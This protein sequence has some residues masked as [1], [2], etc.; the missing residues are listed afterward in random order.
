MLLPGHQAAKVRR[1]AAEL[2]VR[3]LGGD[4]SLVE[5]VCRIR[6]FQEE[7][8][9]R[10]PEDPRRAFGEAI[11]AAS[12][13]GGVAGEQLARMCTEIVTRA[14]P[15]VLEKLTAHIDERL[16]HLD[17][18]QRVKLNVRTP[19]RAS[20]YP[21]ATSIAGAGRPYPLAKFLDDKERE[22]PSW[23]SVRRSF[24]PTCGMITQ[25]L[26]KH[27]C[28]EAGE[29]ATYVEQ[30]HRP[31]LLY[32]EEDR[33]LMQEAWALTAAYREDLAGRQCAS[34]RAVLDRP[35]VID[36]LRDGRE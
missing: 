13:S 23:K 25:V 9:A 28:R 16:A 22:D 36:M 33:A 1:Q 15:A 6:G 5:E 19:K 26:K 14:L 12:G 21:I 30:N 2:L 29:Q 34:P 32:T 24:A 11:E 10:A 17:S 20:P 3:F 27:Q 35:T 7:L 31:Q 18:R 8:A 4:L